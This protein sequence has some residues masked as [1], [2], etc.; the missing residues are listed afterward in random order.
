MSRDAEGQQEYKLDTAL[1]S[2][3]VPEKSRQELLSSKLNKM[4]C[5]PP[6]V[7]CVSAATA[8][9]RAALRGLIRHHLRRDAEGQQE[10]ELDAALHSAIVP[11]KSRHELLSSKL[12]LRLAKAEPGH[13]P[14]LCS[15]SAGQPAPPNQVL[16]YPTSKR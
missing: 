12:E 2:T 8:L 3:I 11:E 15:S 13:W 1:H 9:L 14:D 7:R 5:L 4:A 6:L 10:Y 16:A